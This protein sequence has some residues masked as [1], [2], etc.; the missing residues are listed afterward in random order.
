MEVTNKI[1]TVIPTKNIKMEIKRPTTHV[2]N[3]K[4]QVTTQE[5]KLLSNDPD[6]YKTFTFNNVK[7]SV[8]LNIKEE[9]EYY[10]ILKI[11]KNKYY[12][13]MGCLDEIK[14]LEYFKQM[15]LEDVCF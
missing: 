2:I 11:N 12:I 15:V 9:E 6:F 13:K 3:K 14:N 7:I 1:D 5:I 4:S 10:L 8:Y